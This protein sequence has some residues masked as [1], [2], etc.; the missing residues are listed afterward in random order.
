MNDLENPNSEISIQI[1]K[2]T[3]IY[4]LKKPFLIQYCENKNLK[5]TGNTS[6]LRARIS[7]YIKGVITLD[8]IKDTL[9]KNEQDIVLNESNSK[10]I[11]F[12]KLIEDA[13]LSDSSPEKE[14]SNTINK[15]FNSTIT[16]N[17]NLYE[18]LN[19]SVN[20]HINNTENILGAYS[21]LIETNDCST[22]IV[23]HFDNPTFTDNTIYEDINPT[24]NKENKLL[25]Y[26]P[27]INTNKTESKHSKMDRN[28]NIIIKPESFSGQSDIKQFIKQYEKAGTINNW[29]D[30]D[31]IQ[32]LSIFLKDTASTFLENLEN[33][34]ENWTWDEIKNEFLIEFQ[35]IGYSI[36]LKNKL[37]NRKQGDLESITSFVTDIEN[38]CR[39]VDRNMKEDDICIYILK[40]I[41][42]PILQAISLH[43]NSDLNKLKNNL[44][45]YEL[46]QFRINSRSPNFNEFNDLLN[47]QITQLDKYGKNRDEEIK[48]L[49]RQI[50][51]MCEQ[52]KDINIVDKSVKFKENRGQS[53]DKRDRS[54]SRGR[55][56][57]DKSPYPR[58]NDYRS[59]ETSTDRHYERNSRNRS[60]SRDRQYKKQAEE[61]NNYYSRN[62]DRNRD[63]S[64]NRDD[65]YDRNREKI[66]YSNQPYERHN[67]RNRYSR[68]RTPENYRG[69]IDDVVC[70]KCDKVG[71]YADRCNN[72]KN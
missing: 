58:R 50:E 23:K 55:Y 29:N 13:G 3:D 20:T 62:Y 45:K 39:Q 14:N 59:G 72:S 67:S 24:N 46:M 19:N 56:D 26:L 70:Y 30:M 42:E 71:H 8:D 21:T 51:Q 4:N 48:D 11:D 60:F 27:P 35:P 44:K 5:S 32:F 37:E 15:L 34:K 25:D 22:V 68:S 47:K 18:N 66:Q 16:D 17:L 64:Y 40:G 57:R 12:K 61:K 1:N 36:L 52:I 31:K 6:E 43:D 7:K 9:N 49:K 65:S 10:K 38:L 54:L 2:A 63:R 69:R 53:Y 33:K 41:R 28:K